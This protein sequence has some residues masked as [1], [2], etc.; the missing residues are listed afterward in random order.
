MHTSLYVE[1]ENTQRERERARESVRARVCERLCVH[2]CVCINVVLA[3]NI[4]EGWFITDS[5]RHECVDVR[6]NL[7]A[8]SLLL[9]D[10]HP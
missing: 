1:T 10:H 3:V 9:I 8:V 4:A 6:R 7:F 2:V 5:L